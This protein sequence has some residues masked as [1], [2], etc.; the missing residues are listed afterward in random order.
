[1]S[2]LTS[3]F[4][5]PT[6]NRVDTS[7]TPILDGRRDDTVHNYPNVDYPVTNCTEWYGEGTPQARTCN[8]EVTNNEVHQ[9]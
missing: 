7:V 1:M 8:P 9:G 4:R 3:T 2:K 5:C 6:C